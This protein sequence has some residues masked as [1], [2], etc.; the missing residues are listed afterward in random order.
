MLVI[1]VDFVEFSNISHCDMF[2]NVLITIYI[3][4]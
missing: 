2:E 1:R 4:A 3:E